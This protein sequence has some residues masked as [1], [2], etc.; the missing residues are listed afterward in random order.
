MATG[1]I[2]SRLQQATV[3]AMKSREKERLGTLR[4]LQAMI[5][6][7]EVDE[8]RH[9]AQEDVIKVLASFQRKVREQLAAARDSGRADVQERSE[10]ELAVVAEFLPAPLDDAEL[11]RVVR[12]AIAEAGAQGPR[13]M[14]RVM[15][16][17]LPRVAG[18]AEGGRV[19]G[20]VK[21]LLQE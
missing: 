7:V 8:R 19:S 18:R 9:L 6:Q 5:K 2:A 10:R 20:V 16:V 13:D 3:A 21:R 1:D 14:G 17:V 12:E 11:E 4:M 15:K